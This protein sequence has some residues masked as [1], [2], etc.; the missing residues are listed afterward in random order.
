MILVGVGG[1]RE[2]EAPIGSVV[3]SEHVH[4]P[5]GA[6]YGPKDRS[7]RPLSF[8]PDS[9]L[10]GISKKSGGKRRAGRAAFVIRSTAS[11]RRAT[12]TQSSIHRPAW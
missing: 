6:K 5:S 4:M 12:P 7:S 9:R 2:E 1:S 8:Q 11:C 3:A 10:I